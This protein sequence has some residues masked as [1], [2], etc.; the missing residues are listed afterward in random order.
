MIEAWCFFGR[1]DGM[2]SESTESSSQNP[3]VIRKEK[4]PERQHYAV[5]RVAQFS[6]LAANR[7]TWA[8][9]LKKMQDGVL[10]ILRD[11]LKGSKSPVVASDTATDVNASGSLQGVQT[12]TCIT[13]HPKN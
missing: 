12:P 5:A 7:T 9:S 2:Q 8:G 4:S 13:Q 10:M 11:L 6:L 1:K 3:Q